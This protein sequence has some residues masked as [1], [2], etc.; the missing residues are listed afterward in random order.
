MFQHTCQV[1][2]KVGQGRAVI[3]FFR[4]VEDLESFRQSSF[5][6]HITHKIPG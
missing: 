5:Y 6:S 2:E 1:Q 4:E 3:V